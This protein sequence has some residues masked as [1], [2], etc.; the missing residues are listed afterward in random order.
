MAQV[1]VVAA[2]PIVLHHAVLAASA[3]RVPLQGKTIFFLN[4]LQ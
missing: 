2:V 4:S 1:E 3:E